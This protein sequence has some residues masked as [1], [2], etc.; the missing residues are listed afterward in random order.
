M[1]YTCE[2]EGCYEEVH[3]RDMCRL[4]YIRWK[5]HG[6][7]NIV[8]PSRRPRIEIEPIKG[9][10]PL[11]MTWKEEIPW[12]AGLLDGE[13][14]FTYAKGTYHL[15]V[16]MVDEDIIQK[17]AGI[18]NKWTSKKMHIHYRER[19]SGWQP[20]YSVQ[21]TG[22]KEVRLVVARIYRFLCERRQGQID[23]M[24]DER[25]QSVNINLEELDLK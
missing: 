10:G 1:S 7:P 14:S 6:D 11:E 19:Q 24:I 5:R 3:A 17:V 20:Q 21:L 25:R 22:K 8:L 9:R 15:Q 13:G 2:I 12:L 18:F 23:A 16:H 4:H